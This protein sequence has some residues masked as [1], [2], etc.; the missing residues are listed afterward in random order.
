MYGEVFAR[1][2]PDV[3]SLNLGDF[4]SGL[5][6]F[7]TEPADDHVCKVAGQ[8][9]GRYGSRL[10]LADA[11]HLATALEYNADL[12]VTNDLPFAKIASQVITTK[13]LADYK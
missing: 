10:R 6:S 1:H 12:L 4:F 11:I 7:S 8:L 3:S 2:V 13:T 5:S 9:R